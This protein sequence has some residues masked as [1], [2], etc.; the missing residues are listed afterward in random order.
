MDNKLPLVVLTGPTAVGKTDLSI[1]LAKMI[2]AEIISADSMQVYKRMDIGTAK[3]KNEE[4]DG[5]IHHMIDIL[6]PTEDFNVVMFVNMAKDLIND[7]SKRGHIP[8]IAG[9]TGFYIQALLKNVEFTSHDSDPSFREN[10]SEYAKEHGAKA[11]HDRLKKVDPEYAD[12]VHFNN[13][14]RVIR[15]LEYYEQTGEKFSDHNK[16]EALRGSPYNYAYFVLGD[17]REN[18]YSRIN[19]RVDIMLENGLIDEVRALLKE[20]CTSDM[21][22]MQGLGYKEI[23]GYLNGEYSYDEAVTM[24]K[25]ETRHFAK[26]QLTWFR[27]EKD[28]IWFDKSELSN[29]DILDGM[30]RILIN[31]HIF[32]NTADNDPDIQQN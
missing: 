14:K 13:I 4:M 7:I 1:K 2:N 17:I 24:L 29:D 5:V 18:V 22:S 8:L 9:G 19:K 25:K 30:I 10:L 20:G 3:I 27:R 6:E 16:R 21:V 28:T 23:I 15:A 12:E 32:S 31:R 11:L 26:R